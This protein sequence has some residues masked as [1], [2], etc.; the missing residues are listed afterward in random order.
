ME[1]VTRRPDPESA[2]NPFSTRR[3]RPGAIGYCFPQG[4]SA[5]TLVERLENNGW[6]GQIVGPHGS[7]KSALAATLIR[8]I[9]ETGRKTLLIALHDQQRRLPPGL[10]QLPDLGAGTVVFVDGY[11]QLAWWRRLALVRL[12]RRRSLGLVVTSHRSMGLP[13]LFR[14]TTGLALARR[15]AAELLRET[16]SPI[17]PEE[18]DEPFHLHQGNIREVL[19]DLYDLY[20]Q[21]R[22]GSNA[23]RPPAEACPPR[24][25]SN[26][27]D[28]QDVE[29]A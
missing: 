9:E 14:T 28:C 3:V 4:R 13:D 5:L 21:Q 11:E 8:A 2:E 23:S 25:P 18:V 7:G 15:I 16:D 29:N 10:G 27:A 22:C 17:G 24:P 19:F 1:S 12:C 26:R 6:Q 20:E